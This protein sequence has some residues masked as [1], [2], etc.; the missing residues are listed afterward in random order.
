MKAVRTITTEV[1]V[2]GGG[3]AGVGAGLAAARA[4]ARVLLIEQYGFLGGMATAALALP[5]RFRQDFP[6]LLPEF[7]EILARC[8]NLGV[9]AEPFPDPEEARYRMIIIDPETI[10]YILQEYVLAAGVDLLLHAKA[11]TLRRAQEK[12]VEA[13]LHC[14]EGGVAVHAAAFIDATG[15]GV[16]CRASLPVP[17]TYSFVLANLPRLRSREQGLAGYLAS[18]LREREALGHAAMNNWLARL[19]SE[20]PAFR[21]ILQLRVDPAWRSG[22][23]LVHLMLAPEAP[24]EDTAALTHAE[25]LGQTLSHRLVE[26]FRKNAAGYEAA[27]ILMAPAQ[28]GLRR[29]GHLPE[30]TD[31]GNLLAAGR[32]AL[33]LPSDSVWTSLAPHTFA[34]G[35][36]AGQRAAAIAGA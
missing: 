4:G 33:L 12:I 24:P 25:V 21:E 30:T 23:L 7:E 11:I 26:Y 34:S 14:R 10:K 20:Q 1:A 36:A 29:P 5:W 2:L 31:S 9:C 3:P 32:H 22:E 17:L 15:A 35:A 13:T 16:F 8:R 18:F 6:A 28:V 19:H 27:R